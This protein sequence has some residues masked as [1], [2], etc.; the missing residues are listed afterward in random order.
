MCELTI[1]AATTA[2]VPRLVEMGQ[3]FLQSTVY[4]DL[5]AE[6]P[7]AMAAMATLLVDRADA[8]VLVAESHRLTGMIGLLIC[9]HHIS[10]ERMANEVFW[11]VDP[12]TRGTSGLRLLRAAEAWAREHGAVRMQMVAPD[13]SVGKIYERFGYAPIEIA[14]QRR[15]Q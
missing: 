10:G 12:E 5:L 9:P 7:E 15:L 1:R 3:R 11:W 8:V 6:N 14:Y 13:A 4:R 2:D